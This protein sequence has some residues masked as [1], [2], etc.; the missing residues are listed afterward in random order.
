MT[1]EEDQSWWAGAAAKGLEE[2][3]GEQFGDSAKILCVCLVD[4]LHQVGVAG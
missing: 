1:I 4:I 3:A 2:V